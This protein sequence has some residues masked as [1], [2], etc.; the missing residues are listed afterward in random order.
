MAQINLRPWREE[1][2]A[3]NQKQFMSNLIGSA[4]LAG[5][6]VFG[7]GYY[8]DMQMER[9]QARNDFLRAENTRLD[10]Q[11][12]E[13]N[14]LNRLRAQ[15]LERLQAIEDLQGTRPLIVRNFDELVRVL[16]DDLYYTSVSRSGQL[17]TID[18]FAV[19]NRDVSNL[20]R[21]LNN[22]VLFGEPNLTRVGSVDNLRQF[23]LSVPMTRPANEGA[24]Q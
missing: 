12:A 21:N 22:S 1:R 3:L 20:M 18:G 9:Q 19:Q 11:L 15:L 7:I 17:I 5:L 4:I 14:E 24:A 8:Y 6:F 10:I 16:P 13:I 23:N 2:N